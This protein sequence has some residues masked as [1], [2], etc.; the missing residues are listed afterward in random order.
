MTNIGLG[1]S[2]NSEDMSVFHRH[3]N[4]SCKLTV[5]GLEFVEGMGMWLIIEK[6][7]K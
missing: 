1:S 3:W 6:E 4:L 2:P 5:L 7:F